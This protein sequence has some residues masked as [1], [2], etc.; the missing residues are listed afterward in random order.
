[1][2]LVDVIVSATG[3]TYDFELEETVSVEV[4]IREMQEIVCQKEHR[5]FEE[6]AGALCLYSKD[7]EKRLLPDWTLRQCGI[8]SG[9]TLILL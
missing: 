9:E 6:K 4:L 3:R 1:M 8:R 2:I 7:K 5:R